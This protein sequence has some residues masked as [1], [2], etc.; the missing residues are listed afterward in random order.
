MIRW[1]S[2]KRLHQVETLI[3]K[4]ATR[5]EVGSIT[6]GPNH[7]HHASGAHIRKR[8]PVAQP[9]TGTVASRQQQQHN[10]QTAGPLQPRQ[11]ML[12]TIQR[13]LA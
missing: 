4:I 2:P 1:P 12:A 5:M 3:L 8:R 9:Q 13:L 11:A 7:E 6:D 10:R